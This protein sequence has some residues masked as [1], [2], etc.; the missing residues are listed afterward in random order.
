MR[1][2][3]RASARA[4]PGRCACAIARLGAVSHGVLAR[5]FSRR[6][7]ALPSLLFD[8]RSF[9]EICQNL[10]A[11]CCFFF[12]GGAGSAFG[13]VSQRGSF[14]GFPSRLQPRIA[15]RAGAGRRG[16]PLRMTLLTGLHPGAEEPQARHYQLLHY[17]ESS[18]THALGLE[19]VR[20]RCQELGHAGEL[21]AYIDQALCLSLTCAP[22]RILTDIM[23]PLLQGEKP[24]RGA[25]ELSVLKACS[26]GRCSSHQ[27]QFCQV[28]FYFF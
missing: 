22:H 12:S 3:Y 1:S 27:L 23:F 14:R 11:K 26:S 4:G 21:Q 25:P 24:E 18:R 20:Q 19:K 17:R 16:L 8:L 6:Q 28:N 10:T 5:G 13:R 2:P 9:P 7:A 15:T